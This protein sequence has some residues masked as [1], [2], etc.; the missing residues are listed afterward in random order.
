MQNGNFHLIVADF[1]L[2]VIENQTENG[3]FHLIVVDFQLK[4]I[5]NHKANDNFDLIAFDFL[6]IDGYYKFYDAFYN[7]KGE[8]VGNR[9][10]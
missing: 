4:V 2:K 8:D 3:N 7:W 5:E 10:S 9:L 1:Q 6:F